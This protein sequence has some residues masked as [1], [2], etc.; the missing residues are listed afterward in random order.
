MFFLIKFFFSVC[1]AIAT[2]VS[3]LQVHKRSQ[4]VSKPGCNLTTVMHS[5]SPGTPL[6]GE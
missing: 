3:T 5:Y 2:L 4:I 6:T 1:A